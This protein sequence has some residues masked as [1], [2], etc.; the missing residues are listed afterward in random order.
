MI[1]VESLYEEN[2]EPL[3]EKTLFENRLEYCRKN[4]YASLFRKYTMKFDSSFKLACY[5]GFK[6]VELILT[7]LETSKDCS[8]VWF[9]DADAM[10]MNMNIKIE[11]IVK[12]YPGDILIGSDCNGSSCGSMIVKNSETSK[13]YLKAILQNRDHYIHEQDYFWKN[14]REFIVVT[15]QRVM[16]SWDCSLPNLQSNDLEGSQFQVGDFFIHWP[17]QSLEKRLECYEQWKGK[18]IHG[19]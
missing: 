19:N 18:V 15:P 12:K 10:V 8:H 14:P 7:V 1:I 2:Y 13:F 11:D 5:L 4:N 16:N 3:A 9:A 17:S 6:K